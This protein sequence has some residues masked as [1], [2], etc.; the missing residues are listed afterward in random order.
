MQQEVT[1]TNA[2]S[3][4]D[5]ELF[6]LDVMFDGGAPFRLLRDE[7]FEC[8]WNRRS[9]GLSDDSLKTTL[10]HLV[11]LGIIYEMQGY[12]E[13]FYRFTELGGR[14][15]EAEREPKWNRYAIDTYGETF[16]CKPTITIVATDPRIRDEFWSIGCDVGLFAY[17]GGR[18][19]TAAIRKHELIYWKT[20]EQIHVLVA[21]IDESCYETDWLAFDGHRTFWRSVHENEKFRNT[22]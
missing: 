20:F 5:T 11:S 2:T 14:L 16:S 13:T 3:L 1:R 15:W 10:L 18:R 17:S 6:L 7:A 4:Q 21:I 19:R 8:Q 22:A 12:D 9:H